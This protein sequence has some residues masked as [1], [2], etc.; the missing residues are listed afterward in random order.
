[1]KT[2]AVPAGFDRAAID[3]QIDVLDKLWLGQPAFNIDPD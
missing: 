2:L 1:M 3:V